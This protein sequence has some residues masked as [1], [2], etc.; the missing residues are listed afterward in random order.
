[1]VGDACDGGGGDVSDMK[2]I[3]D[4]Y[5]PEKRLVVAKLF[6]DFIEAVTEPIIQAGF[7]EDEIGHFGEA[8][9]QTME[10]VAP[11]WANISRAIGALE[12]PA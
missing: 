1:M 2:A 11:A 9:K 10:N 5:S 12:C 3:Y 4:S 8:L 6:D 7:T